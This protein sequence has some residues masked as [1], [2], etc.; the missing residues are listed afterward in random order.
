MLSEFEAKRGDMT[1]PKHH[2][3]S[4]MFVA[5]LV[6]ALF[7]LV[8]CSSQT[9][10][11]FKVAN[12]VETACL[13]GAFEMDI[14]EGMSSDGVQSFSDDMGNET[15]FPDKGGTSSGIYIHSTEIS[16]YL[17]ADTFVSTYFDK[18]PKDATYKYRNIK[19][20]EMSRGHYMSSA[21]LYED[22]TEES[23]EKEVCFSMD[24]N[25][26]VTI[27]FENLQKSYTNTVESSIR[28]L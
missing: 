16:P 5:G 9:V 27:S 22:G 20:K 6:V 28:I 1:K 13:N 23:K 25:I 15:F 12:T 8:G 14:P 21:D 19:I 7:V 3:S 2:L 24:G 17:G 26:V 10:E 4:I 18:P 11:P